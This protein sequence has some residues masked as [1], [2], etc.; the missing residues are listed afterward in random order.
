MVSDNLEG[1]IL[2]GIFA[3]FYTGNTSGVFDNRIQEVGFKVGLLFLYNGSKSLQTAARIDVLMSQ[4]LVG[5][6]FLLVVLREYEVPDFEI[7]VAVTA[8][9]AVR[10]AAAAFFAQVDVD[11][12]VR[13][14][15]ARADFP[16]VIF[17][18]DD[19]IL[20]E[21]RLGFPDFDG[22]IIIRINRNPEFVLRQFH[23]FRQEFPCPGNSFAL[24]V[25]AKG[26][27]AQHFKE[28]LMAGGAADIFDI[29]GTHAA[30]TGR[31]TRAGRLHL[32]REERLQRRH[33]CTNQEQGRI[34]LRNQRETRQAKMPF[35]FCKELQI[36]FAQFVTT[37]I[38]QIK[39][40]PI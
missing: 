28:R 10:R 9:S 12:G 1:D 18:L 35:L 31:H 34:I 37:H 39:S 11:F 32:A 15:G 33:T 7:P 19:M 14:A 29:A 24:E 17:H 27:V 22:F 5:T 20:R 30:L 23:N 40:T 4:V 3:V 26:E 8:N 21:A 36:S 13:T 2:F 6:I 25:I 38:L 16:E